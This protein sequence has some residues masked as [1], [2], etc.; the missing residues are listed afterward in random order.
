VAENEEFPKEKN[1]LGG[2]TFGWI[3]RLCIKDGKGEV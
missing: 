2:I 3:D 1:L